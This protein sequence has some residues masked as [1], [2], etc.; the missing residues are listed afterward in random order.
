MKN[1]NR[2]KRLS[3][4]TNDLDNAIEDLVEDIIEKAEKQREQNEITDYSVLFCL[5]D[6][7]RILNSYVDKAYKCKSRTKLIAVRKRFEGFARF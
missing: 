6:N 4:D 2:I 7:L 1:M 5:M 3:T